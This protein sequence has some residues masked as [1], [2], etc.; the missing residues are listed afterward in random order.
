MLTVRIGKQSRAMFMVPR[1]F[2]GSKIETPSSEKGKVEEPLERTVFYEAPLAK[3]VQNL[4]RVSITTALLSLTIPPAVIFGGSES[5]PISGQIAITVVTMIAS[6]GS[7][8]AIHYLFSPYILT[9]A[10]LTGA[11]KP[12]NPGEELLEAKTMTLFATQ[13]S[14]V[15]KVKD[16]SAK[17]SSLRP[18]V[19]FNVK[20]KPYFVH[21]SV[22]DDKKLLQ[23][24]LGRPLNENEI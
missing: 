1:R 13:K 18:F 5:V 8:S 19:S 2:A 14:H 23:K 12:T 7:T 24:M 16:C 10:K 6:L 4:K 21:A 17:T 3:A 22:F 20:D 9:L 11:N 15:F